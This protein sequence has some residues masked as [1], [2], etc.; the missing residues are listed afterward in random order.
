MS[1]IT[2]AKEKKT[3]TWHEESAEDAAR[4]KDKANIA[5]SASE[6]DMYPQQNRQGQHKGV[7][8]IN[9]ALVVFSALVEAQHGELT[10]RCTGSIVAEVFW[11]ERRKQLVPANNLGTVTHGIP[12]VSCG[13]GASV[14]GFESYLWFARLVTQQRCRWCDQRICLVVATTRSAFALLL[15]LPVPLYCPS[16][17][18]PFWQMW[19]CSLTLDI[20][21]HA[22]EQAPR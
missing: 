8:S 11:L 13:K 4:T 20:V 12:R 2:L 1:N 6:R 18:E 14:T 19:W 22:C 17:V 16:E 5:S 15:N 21:L 3:T 9:N 7:H 10:R